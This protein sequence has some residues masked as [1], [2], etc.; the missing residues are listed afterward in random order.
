MREEPDCTQPPL[1]ASFDSFAPSPDLHCRLARLS[2]R[3]MR[4]RRRPQAQQQAPPPYLEQQPSD[5]F[6]APH[7]PPNAGEQRWELPLPVPG[8]EAEQGAKRIKPTEELHSRRPDGDPGTRAALPPRP[9]VLLRP[10]TGLQLRACV[11][12]CMPRRSLNFGS[13]LSLRSCQLISLHPA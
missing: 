4:I 9:Q 8:D 10:V 6:A 5:P 12:A 13:N 11:R 3:P 7:P 2:V 1:L